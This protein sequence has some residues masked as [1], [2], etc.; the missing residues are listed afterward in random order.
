MQQI[1]PIFPC[2]FFISYEKLDE[3][4]STS[5]LSFYVHPQRSEEAQ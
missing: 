3:E 1:I 2:A 5:E 4:V